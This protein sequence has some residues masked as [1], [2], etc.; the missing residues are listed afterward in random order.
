MET[1]QYRP[2]DQYIPIPPSESGLQTITAEYFLQVHKT[3]G[4]H[5]EGLCFDRH[6]N[7]YFTVL[8]GGSVCRINMDTKEITEVFHD[9]NLKPASV[10]IH[11]DGRLFISC[12]N[13]RVGSEVQKGRIFAINPDGTGY[14]DIVTGYSADDLVFDQDG[15]FYFTDLVG[16]VTNPIGAVYHVSPDFKTV[17]PFMEH[18]ATPNGVTLSTDNSVLWITESHC[19]RIHR[20]MRSGIMTSNMVYQ[21]PGFYGPDSCSV[22]ADD[23][24]YV[25]MCGQGRVLVFNFYGMPIGQILLPNR[26]IGHNLWTTHPVVRPDTN[27]LY[28]ISCDD[29]GDEGSWIFKAG[30]F[31]KGPKHYFQFQ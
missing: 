30:A 10:K 21:T 4:L 9:E 20:I 3:R 6:G 27:E 2:G 17:T 29:V 11:K 14:Q 22:D 31:G 19:G 15:G 7:L 16:D 12:I 18:M 23:N 5:T 28:I 8:Y 1:L 26:E 25:A 24:L 13:K